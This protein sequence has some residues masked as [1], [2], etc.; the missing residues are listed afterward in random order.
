M[1]VSEA[2]AQLVVNVEPWP[3]GGAPVPRHSKQAGASVSTVKVAVSPTKTRFGPL[4]PPNRGSTTVAEACATQ[5]P[6]RYVTVSVAV[7][8]SPSARTVACP[9]PC[10]GIETSPLADQPNEPPAGCPVAVNPA[11]P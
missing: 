6:T 3:P 11:D 5:S 9:A 10:A 4:I 2:A 7:E 8:P 1:T